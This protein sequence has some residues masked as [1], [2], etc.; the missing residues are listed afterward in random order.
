MLKE[1]LLHQK[2]NFIYWSDGIAGIRTCRFALHPAGSDVLTQIPVCAEPLHFEAFFCMKGRLVIQPFRHAP[3][4][5]EAPGVFLF[6]DSSSLY[7]C[8]CSKDLGGVF[9]T[10]DAAAAK[11]SLQTI[12]S[13]LGMEFNTKNVRDR[14]A[15]ANGYISLSATPWV[16][17]FF[18]T[19]K[20]LPDNA[21]ER[22][23]VF[24]C[25]ELLYLLCSEI[26]SSGSSKCEAV[27]IS[28]TMIKIRDYMQEHLSKKITIQLLCREFLVSPT[29][30]K[31]NFRRAYGMPIHTWLIRQRIKRARELIGTTQMPIQEVAQAVGYES[32]S[33][34]NAAFKR[35]YGI[36]PGQCR[37]MSETASLRP[38]L[39]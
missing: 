8:Q 7:G 1:Y 29:F 6:S 2:S 25:V 17:A 28:R 34:F 12:C 13:A 19:M 15:A 24:K 5:V 38:F 20:R 26:S 37:K 11:E 32:I 33:Q 39:Q 22:Y 3:C 4:S 23:C 16:R 31:E 36:T 30:L 10:V 21:Q 27:C 18:E 14:M 9:V 35:H